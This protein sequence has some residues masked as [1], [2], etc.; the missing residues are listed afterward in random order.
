[1]LHYFP[2]GEVYPR[3]AVMLCWENGM[4]VISLAEALH[5]GNVSMLQVNGERCTAIVRLQNKS[6]CGA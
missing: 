6:P 2:K 1:M 3:A 4:L 5:G